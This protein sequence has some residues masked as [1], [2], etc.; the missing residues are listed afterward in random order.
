MVLLLQPLVEA[1][2][3]VE[4]D[5]G[6]VVA[7]QVHALLILVVVVVAVVGMA[8]FLVVIDEGNLIV[9][10]EEVVVELVLEGGGCGNHLL[11][12][13]GLAALIHGRIFLRLATLA[14]GSAARSG[15]ILILILTQPGDHL[16]L[17]GLGQFSGPAAE[18]P[19]PLLADLGQPVLVVHPTLVLVILIVDDGVDDA[20]DSGGALSTEIAGKEMML[21]ASGAM[22]LG[23]GVVLI[24]IV[25]KGRMAMVVPWRE[26]VVA[27]LPAR[28]Q[29]DLN[30]NGMSS[31][32]P[33]LL[34]GRRPIRSLLGGG[35]VHVSTDPAGHLRQGRDEGVAD[36]LVPGDAPAGLELAGGGGVGRGE[37]E[38]QIGRGRGSAKDRTGAARS[39]RTT[40]LG[41]VVLL[42][43]INDT[44]AL[45][46]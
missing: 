19:R 46:G 44:P 40:V 17:V 5:V 15:H 34:L 31:Q 38:I 42:F 27:V 21:D 24:A 20:F 29:V 30:Y 9:E 4:V 1:G 18:R 23:A 10:V 8:I 32:R 3:R 39:R 25:G 22:V 33:D 6:K 2:V 14:T 41:D 26:Q 45:G 35:V 16:G 43:V 36:G 28:G 37:V 12:P 11:D 13:E 7:V